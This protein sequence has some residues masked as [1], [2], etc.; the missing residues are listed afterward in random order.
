MRALLA[1]IRH[2]RQLPRQESLALDPD[3]QALRTR[4]AL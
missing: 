2:E 3:A 4:T 1:P